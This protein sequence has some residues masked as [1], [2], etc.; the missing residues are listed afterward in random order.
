MPFTGL[1]SYGN[2]DQRWSLSLG[3]L[4]VGLNSELS[5]CGSA[6]TNSPGP[7]RSSWD[8]AWLFMVK[9]CPHSVSSVHIQRRSRFHFP[10][11]VPRPPHFPF[12]SQD[13]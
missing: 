6:C 11:L 8:L 2:I 4:L 1:D 10:S 12:A 7:R 9:G 3:H 13:S 5:T